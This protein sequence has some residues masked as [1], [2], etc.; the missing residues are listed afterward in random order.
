MIAVIFEVQPAP[1]REQEYLDIAAELRPVLERMDGFISVERFRSLADPARVLSLSFWRDEAAVA[2]WR[3]TGE[4]AIA[5]ARGRAGIFADYRLRIAEVVRDYGMAARREEAPAELR[6]RERPAPP[7]PVAAATS[8]DPYPAYARLAAVAPGLHRDPRIGCWVAASAAAV[9]AV[10]THPACLVR[11]V[12]EP[13]PRALLGTAAGAFFSALMRMTDGPRHAALRGAMRPALVGLA[14]RASKAAEACAG[15]LAAEVGEGRLALADFQLRL[16]AETVGQLIGLPEERLAEVAQWVDA[17][18]RAIAPGAAPERIAPGAVAAEA[19]MAMVRALPTDGESAAANA[20]GLLTQAHEATAGLIGNTLLALAGRAAL[21]A[22]CAND[23]ALLRRVVEEVLR[24]DPP[25]QNTR[26]FLAE[27]AEVCGR[28]LRAG[29]QVLVLLGAA[30]R[31][32]AVNAAPDVFDPDRVAPRRFAFGAGVHACPGEAIAITIAVEGVAA[33]LRR[34]L[35]SERPH[36][37]N[38]R[39]S[40]NARVPL[41]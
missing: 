16:P 18:A 41:L 13:V 7:D 24:H 32:P 23:P 12:E 34:G 20:V 40:L 21:R 38:Y 1:G 10:L 28:S 30:G 27:D 17:L 39:A 36:E 31:D 4:H 25:V 22:A 6:A 26:R 3:N 8:P 9:E 35:A 37:V 14:E 29:E 2:A 19:L 11:P 33:L 15:R 5:Q